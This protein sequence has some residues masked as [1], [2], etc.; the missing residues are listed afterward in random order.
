VLGALWLIGRVGRQHIIGGDIAAV[1]ADFTLRLFVS[2]DIPGLA[3]RHLPD[4]LFMAV[5]RLSG[6]AVSG[7]GTRADLPG[8]APS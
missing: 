7:R 2:D 5:M 8:A 4:T 6:R 3:N 1:K